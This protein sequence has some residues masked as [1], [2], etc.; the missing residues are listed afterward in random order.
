M[1]PFEARLQFSRMLSGLQP[2]TQALVKCS[3]FALRNYEYQDDFHSCILEVLE[4]VSFLFV[5]CLLL[6][7]F[8]LSLEMSVRYR[9]AFCFILK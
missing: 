4:M 5:S 7:S 9:L 2:V 8:Y 6:F 3:S 1:D